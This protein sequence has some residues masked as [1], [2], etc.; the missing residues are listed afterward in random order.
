MSLNLSEIPTWD[1][2]EIEL[3]PLSVF[4]GRLSTINPVDNIQDG[5]DKIWKLEHSDK[6][7]ITDL[8]EWLEVEESISKAV[9]IATRKLALGGRNPEGDGH[10]VAIAEAIWHVIS[11]RRESRPPLSCNY[12][13]TALIF[14]SIDEDRDTAEYAVCFEDP[15]GDLK[16]MSQQG[17]NDLN[18][19]GQ[20]NN[21]T[22]KVNAGSIIIFPSYLRHVIYHTFEDTHMNVIQIQIVFPHRS[23]NPAV[24]EHR[25][26]LEK[27]S[28]QQAV[29]VEDASS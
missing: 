3:F 23:K 27:E 29:D 6:A 13:M 12:E 24:I 11:P 19:D 8:P 16:K 10:K 5:L 1:N 28:L 7:N 21:K 2:F 4:A 26:E 18:L 20:S 25:F 22:I 15:A 14:N 9:A 17:N